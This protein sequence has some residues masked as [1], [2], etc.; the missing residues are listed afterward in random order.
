M[1]EACTIIIIR[2]GREQ[3]RLDPAFLIYL[4]AG[5]LPACLCLPACLPVLRCFNSRYHSLVLAEGQ[6]CRHIQALLPL[7]CVV[8]KTF[9]AVDKTPDVKP[10]TA[11]MKACDAAYCND[12]WACCR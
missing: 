10:V 6:K 3:T 2:G 5:W 8:G 9:A 4:M 11:M 12:C 7:Y 1:E